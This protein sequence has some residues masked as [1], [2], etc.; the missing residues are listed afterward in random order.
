MTPAVVS[1]NKCTI[2]AGKRNRRLLQCLYLVYTPLISQSSQ[3]LLRTR[4]VTCD[5]MR[6]HYLFIIISLAHSFIHVAE[7]LC[8]Y[9][10]GQTASESSEGTTIDY[11]EK[12]SCPLHLFPCAPSALAPRFSTYGVPNSLV[13]D[14]WRRLRWRVDSARL[15]TVH[16]IPS[17]QFSFTSCALYISSPF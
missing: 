9:T 6:N 17:A 2:F 13:Q 14:E 8:I 1:T 16:G 15:L 5:G 7:I 10:A 4:R 12:C 11:Y 3:A